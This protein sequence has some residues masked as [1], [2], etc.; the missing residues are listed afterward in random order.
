[1]SS[2]LVRLC[3]DGPCFGPCKYVMV[4]GSKAD[5]YRLTVVSFLFMGAQSLSGG[6]GIAATCHQGQGGNGSIPLQAMYRTMGREE[7]REEKEKKR[8]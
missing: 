6:L 5:L 8:N 4:V 3:S 1:M 2:V 7:D